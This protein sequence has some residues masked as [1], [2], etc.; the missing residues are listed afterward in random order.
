MKRRFS[1]LRV[2]RLGYCPA[3]ESL[4]GW[5]SAWPLLLMVL[6]ATAP[7]AF[8]QMPLILPTIEAPGIQTSPVLNDPEATGVAVED[9][10]RFVKS[11][12]NPALISDS[13]LGTYS[14]GRGTILTPGADKAGRA[15]ETPYFQGASGANTVT[16]MFNTPQRYF[17]L[18]WSNANPQFPQSNT[19]T[20][21][22]NANGQTNLPYSFNTGDLLALINK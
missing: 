4:S 13:P 11:N 20:F 22:L 19:L 16:L 2:G 17:G 21:S 5:R 1:L 9:F 12:S 18:W 10:N 15:F 6:I 7:R 14:P 8:S 3:V